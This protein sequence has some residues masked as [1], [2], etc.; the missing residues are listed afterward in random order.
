MKY[1]ILIVLACSSITLCNAQKLRN[2]F[3]YTTKTE[4]EAQVVFRNRRDTTADRY[5]KT[6]INGFNSKVPF[7]H[8]INI[9]NRNKFVFILHGLNGSKDNWL[10]PMSDGKLVDSLVTLGY[11]VIIPDAK[12]HGERSYEFNFRPTGGLPPERSRSQKDAKSLYEVYSST[13]KDIRIIMD[14]FEKQHA[15]EKLQ[16]DL[17]GYSM[18]GA[19]SLIVN[20]IDTRINSVA[21]CVPPVNRPIEEIKN[22]GWPNE[23]AENM[24]DISPIYYATFQKSPV[25]LLMGRTDYFTSEE[26]ATVFFDGIPNNDK[27]LKFYESG[28]SLPSEY[29][30][31]VIEWITTHNK[32]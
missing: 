21:S 31:D 3:T 29:I 4:F 2:E 8:Y 19:I 30:N 11:N 12:F 10:R 1:L 26:E 18:G 27:H 20:A 16:F 24:K 9:E 15:G 13:I 17:I 5:E 32:K 23:I 22:F 28:H 25:A 6:V 14:Y 7:Y